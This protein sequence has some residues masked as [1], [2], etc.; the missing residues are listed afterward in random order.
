[1]GLEPVQ[2]VPLPA[3]TLRRNT[4]GFFCLFG[5]LKN[6]IN[7]IDN[8]IV[9]Y[10][11]QSPD[12]MTY[13]HVSE[14]NGSS[15]FPTSQILLNEKKIDMNWVKQFIFSLN[16]ISEIRKEFYITMLQKRYEKILYEPYKKLTNIQ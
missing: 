10:A 4:E 6:K 13:S 15:L 8:Y 14:Y 5:N 2:N 16:E 12:G 7:P 11:K 3:L 1:M 9:K